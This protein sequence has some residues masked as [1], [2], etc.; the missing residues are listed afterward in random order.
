MTAPQTAKRIGQAL[1]ERLKSITTANGY[2]TNAGQHVYR[3]RLDID[4]SILQ[5]IT[6]VEL[7]ENTTLRPGRTNTEHKPTQAYA[8][9]A[10]SVCDANNPNDTAHDLIIDIKR[11]LF[12]PDDPTLGGLSTA[13]RYVRRSIDARQAGTDRITAVV[14]VEVDYFENLVQ[15]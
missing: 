6:L 15:P 5:Y 12:G 9:E 4:A 13:L 3:G 11:A 14:Q 7:D 8:I 1:A 2:H 10:G